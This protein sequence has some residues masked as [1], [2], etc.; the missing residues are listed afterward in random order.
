MEMR[1][2]RVA[3][4]IAVG[5]LLRARK[6]PESL[7][8]KTKA[9]DLGLCLAKTRGAAR[10]AT[11]AAPLEK[12]KWPENEIASRNAL[13]RF[14]L[15]D[16]ERRKF[17]DGVSGRNASRGDETLS[18]YSS[19]FELRSRALIEFPWGKHPSDLED[20]PARGERDDT[21]SLGGCQL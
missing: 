8:C 5:D 9:A 14:L 6:P 1:K 12:P 16:E 3:I 10:L 18:S 17:T 2:D 19:S 15:E 20:A 13:Y 7:D 4:A 21:R 11:K